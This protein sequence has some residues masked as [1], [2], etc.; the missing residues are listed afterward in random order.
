MYQ[1]GDRVLY[2]IH[3]VCLIL[4]TE[5]KSVDR[6]KVEYYVLEPMEQPGTRYYVPTQ[7]Q[8]AVAKLRPVLDAETLQALL[9]SDAVRK[10]S[11]IPDENQRKLHYRELINSGDRA[12]L[13]GMV[14]TLHRHK[15]ELVV[16][17]RKFHLCDENFLRD[18]EKLLYAE[19]S[20]VLGIEPAKVGEYVKTAL[21]RGTKSA[22]A[23]DKSTCQ[24]EQ[25]IR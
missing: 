14:G 17:G 15:Q 4:G 8:T 6:K 18:T 2:G 13:L 9:R 24:T 1:Q 19:L 10:D 12:A 7:N 21:M 16:Q 23:V 11:W 20:L 25:I 3:G 5:L 22:P